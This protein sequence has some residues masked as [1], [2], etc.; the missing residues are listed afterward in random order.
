MSDQIDTIT[1]QIIKSLQSISSIIK[2]EGN[3]K[4]QEAW[5]SAL[6]GIKEELEPYEEATLKFPSIEESMRQIIND[7]NNMNEDERRIF[8]TDEQMAVISQH[9]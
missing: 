5:I 3:F 1:N 7:L 9:F 8:V 6:S 2:I 4:E